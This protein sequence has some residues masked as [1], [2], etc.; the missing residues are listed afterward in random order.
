MKL[1]QYSEGIILLEDALDKLESDYINI[2]N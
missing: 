1:K 2:D